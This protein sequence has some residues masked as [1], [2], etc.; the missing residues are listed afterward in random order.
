LEL[1]ALRRLSAGAFGTLMALEPA[2][3]AVI[4]AVALH[5]V[6][7][8]L[9]GL[10]VV[11]VVL[12]GVGAERGG[13]RG[14]APAREHVAAVPAGGAV[15]RSGPGHERRTAATIPPCESHAPSPH[16]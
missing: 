16:G 8:P 13:A 4:G 3:A 1:L 7:G 14:D 12:A 10:G 15:D 6:P 9:G 11:L 2:I 5:Q